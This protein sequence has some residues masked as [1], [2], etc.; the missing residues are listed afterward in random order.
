MKISEVR[1]KSIKDSRGDFTIEVKIKTDV[2]IFSASAP[3]GK[4]KGKHEAKSY[5]KTIEDDIETLKKFSDYFS[6]EHIE[7]FDD[8]RRVEDVIARNIGANTLFALESAVL[9][10][11][12]LE[13]KKEIW[14]LINSNAKTFPRLVGN[15]VGGG[16]H[17]VG[18]NGKKPDFQEFLLIPETKTVKEAFELNK[19]IREDIAN[20]FS[21]IEKGFKKKSS[22]EKGWLTGLNEKEILEILKQKKIDFGVD[23]AAS[24]FFKRKKYHYENPKLDR[25]TDEQLMYLSNLM[26]NFNF[27]YVEDPFGEEDFENFGKLLKMFPNS[28]IVGDD[29]TVTNYKRLEKDQILTFK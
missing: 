4:S 18:I 16:A 24:N 17:S 3:N 15:S 1:G 8:L 5:K 28:L 21:K 11:M 20:N 22:D 2:G 13:Q 6:E 12:A 19:K 23:I 10:A 25:T 14:E 7:K 29:L 9:K 26:K 27:F